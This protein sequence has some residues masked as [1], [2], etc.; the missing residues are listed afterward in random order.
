MAFA[1][2]GRA[3]RHTATRGGRSAPAA[4]R[5]EFGDAARTASPVDDF[6]FVDLI[7]VVFGRRET[8]RNPDRAID[9]HDTAAGPADQMMVIVTD[10]I[11]EARR[12][13]GRLNASHETLGDQDAQRVVHRLVRNRA[14][15]APDGLGDPLGGDMGLSRHGLHHRQ[16]LGGDLKTVFTKPIGGARDHIHTIAQD[17]NDSKFRFI[18][19][20]A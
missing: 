1:A 5:G 3:G 19:L 17:L 10:T 18:R 13:S 9:I 12:R 2:R 6:G 16:T 8:R 7:A 15:V 20:A 11:F 4:G 14:D